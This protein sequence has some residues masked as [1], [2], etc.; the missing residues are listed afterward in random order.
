MSIIVV[1]NTGVRDIRHDIGTS[2]KPDFRS[3][4]FKGGENSDSVA[5]SKAIG[6]NKGARAIGKKILEMLNKDED[7]W[8]RIKVPIL[9][10]AIE[11]VLR[12]E[13]KIDAFYLFYTDQK[14]PNHKQNDTINIAKILEL[15]FKREFKGQISSTRLEPIE[16]DPHKKD[17]AYRFFGQKLPEIA[18]LDKTKTLYVILSSGVPALND[19]L[20]DQAVRMYKKSCRLY[21]VKEIPEDELRKGYESKRVEKAAVDPLIKDSLIGTVESLIQRYDYAGAL[22]AYDEYRGHTFWKKNISCILRYLTERKN[23]NFEEAEKALSK[24][25]ASDSFTKNLCDKAKNF[26]F[27]E[28]F[29]D[30]FHLI[31]IAQENG[32]YTELVWRVRAFYENALRYIVAK[33]LN[34]DP[35]L[36]LRRIDRKILRNKCTECYNSLI[37]DQ[38][39]KKE[40]GAWLVNS[41][42]LKQICKYVSNLG[43]SFG[44]ALQLLKEEAISS[45]IELANNMLHNFRGVSK[46]DIPE[47]LF[48]ILENITKTLFEEIKENPYGEINEYLLNT[49]EKS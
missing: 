29:F 45:T 23:F 46:N 35:L 44:N 28:K 4:D 21:Q 12:E 6:C 2:E 48:S 39:V 13:E 40:K 25:N 16:K 27:D 10:P 43:S 15:F 3:F 36:K 20:S 24:I 14:D 17:V 42:L 34:Y 41:Y 33:G 19:G 47:D 7:V 11:R 9:R 18:P 22:I 49:L 26:T 31:S 5:I 8:K 1:S 37:D 32:D 30:N 38:K